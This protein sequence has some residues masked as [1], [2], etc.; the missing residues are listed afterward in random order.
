MASTHGVKARG[1]WRD[2]IIRSKLRENMSTLVGSA[3]LIDV[4]TFGYDVK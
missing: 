4:K 2:L 1:A 3:I